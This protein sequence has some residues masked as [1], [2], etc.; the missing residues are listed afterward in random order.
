VHHYLVINPGGKKLSQSHNPCFTFISQS[1]WYLLSDLIMLW[2]MIG[3]PDFKPGT[4]VAGGYLPE[5]AICTQ[6]IKRGSPKETNLQSR[7]Q[8]KVSSWSSHWSLCVCKPWALYIQTGLLAQ[9]LSYRARA[10]CK[11]ANAQILYELHYHLGIAYK[12]LN[13]WKQRLLTT[14][15]QFSWLSTPDVE[16]GSLQQSW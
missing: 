12:R 13:D 7:Q 3:L 14:K 6:D 8:W 1:S 5:V 4:P 2:W 15:W 9:V 11:A 10:C 16:T